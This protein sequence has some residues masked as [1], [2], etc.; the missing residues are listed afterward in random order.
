M[1]NFSFLAISIA[2]LAFVSF[3]FVGVYVGFNINETG[4]RDLLPTP[5]SV[6]PPE[7]NPQIRKILVIQVDSLAVEEPQAINIF[8]ISLQASHQQVSIILLDSIGY[9]KHPL[10]DTF[11]LDDQGYFNPL[12]LSQLQKETIIFDRHI[13]LDQFGLETFL[14]WV[15]EN[16]TSDFSEYETSI[17]QILSGLNAPSSLVSEIS[18]L[19]QVT[20]Y[21]PLDTDWMNLLL[22][23]IPKHVR[24]DFPIDTFIVDWKYLNHSPGPF[25]CEVMDP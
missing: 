24:T 18:N 10:V 1:K 16:S 7:R 17:E 12:F 25:S 23:L 9:D 14:N 15:N 2:L 4:S 20:S 11:Q 21:L 13:I 3:V 5:N 19:C 6:T 22:L 8:L